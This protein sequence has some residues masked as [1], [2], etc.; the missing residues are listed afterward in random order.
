[1]GMLRKMDDVYGD[2]TLHGRDLW[3]IVGDLNDFN[4]ATSYIYICLVIKKTYSTTQERV[5]IS[6]TTAI[7]PFR[8]PFRSNIAQT[9][10]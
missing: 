3:G 1:M 4:N 10:G 5:P 2:L 7:K 8:K 9:V 6:W